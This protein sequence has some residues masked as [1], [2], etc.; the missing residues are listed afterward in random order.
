[1]PVVE[2]MSFGLP[3]LLSD[4]P[5]HREVSLNMGVYF[6]PEDAEGLCTRM[7]NMPFEKKSYSEEIQKLFS[8]N[9]TAARYVDLINTLGTEAG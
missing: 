5:P 8:E 9:N 3:V 2:A 6:D 7:L 4:I 1:M